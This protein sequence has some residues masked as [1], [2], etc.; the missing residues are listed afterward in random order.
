MA[1][2]RSVSPLLGGEAAGMTQ[3]TS[4]EDKVIRKLIAADMAYAYRVA[5]QAGFPNF[6][7]REFR[8]LVNRDD[9][10]DVIET[11]VTVIKHVP[12]D[13]TPEEIA[14]V[15]TN[16]QRAKDF[17]ESSGCRA[18]ICPAKRT[19]DGGFKQ[20]DDQRL[21]ISTL[22]TCLRLRPDF[23]V[24]VGADGDY[25]PML[26]ELRSEGIRTEV[27]AVRTTLASDLQRASYS[28]VD[29][30]EIFDTLKRKS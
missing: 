13:D 26:W 1:R 11:L 17:F 12:R 10:V 24:F 7:I 21:M 18:I 22:S 6:P 23:L 14:T 2:V 8:E 28:V 25:A 30:E 29:L 4:W 15:A 19:Q 27:V 16:V 20:S 5:K 3:E 9:T